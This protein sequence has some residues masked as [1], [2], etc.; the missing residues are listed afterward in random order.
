MRQQI[1]RWDAHKIMKNV[2]HKK[3][4][5]GP[6]A[7]RGGTPSPCSP[8]PYLLCPLS[9]SHSLCCYLPRLL[10]NSCCCWQYLCSSSTNSTAHPT[11]L[12]ILFSPPPS[13]LASAPGQVLCSCLFLH[14]CYISQL[15]FCNFDP[16]ATNLRGKRKKEQ[17]ENILT[18]RW[19]SR[20]PGSEES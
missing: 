4:E 14:F 19:Q 3:A 10:H 17:V 12:P 2:H 5:P 1:F 15:L 20:Y 16:Q 7:K 18:L 11:S 13:P 6:Q 9:L 8:L